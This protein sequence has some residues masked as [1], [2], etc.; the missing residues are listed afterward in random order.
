[1]RGIPLWL[2]VRELRTWVDLHP[3]NPSQG[4][5]RNTSA[6]A[7]WR[8]ACL[9][10]EPVLALQL[11]TMFGAAGFELPLIT[12]LLNRSVTVC[13]VVGLLESGLLE[14][15]SVALIKRL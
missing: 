7:S 12:P 1:M 15:G 9:V 4:I 13:S 11:F 3:A 8:A 14:L 2:H 10:R 5:V 6:K